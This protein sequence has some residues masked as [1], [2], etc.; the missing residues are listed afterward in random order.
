MVDAAQPIGLA[1]VVNI[2][3]QV[4]MQEGTDVVYY[5]GL[6]G[7]ELLRYLNVTSGL[8]SDDDLAQFLL[9]TPDQYRYAHQ[10]VCVML[11]V[12][13]DVILQHLQGTHLHLP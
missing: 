11:Q 3:E 2:E 5:T 12:P 7:G 1:N 6:Y 9:T 10:K 4:M 13:E 8:G